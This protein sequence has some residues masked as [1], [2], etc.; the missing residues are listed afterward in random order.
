MGLTARISRPRKAGT[1]CYSPAERSYV[2]SKIRSQGNRTTEVRLIRYCR[3]FDI[4]GWR[5]HSSL[6]GRPDFVFQKERLT[7][8]VDGCFWHGCPKCYRAPRSNQGYWS[9]KLA[10]N[11]SRDKRVNRELAKKG[12]HVLRIRECE[13]RQHPERCIQRIKRSLRPKSTP[14]HR[15]G[16]ASLGPRPASRS[17]PTARPLPRRR[18]VS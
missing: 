8:F 11:R 5:R 9:K 3:R 18:R 12:W 4:K 16:T 15:S 6:D 7:V 14:P 10:G 2:M 13:L 17:S 1:D